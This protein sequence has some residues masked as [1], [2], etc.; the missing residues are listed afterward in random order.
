MLHIEVKD[1]FDD[2]DDAFKQ[3]NKNKIK[4]HNVFSLYTVWP[5]FLPGLT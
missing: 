3:D 2:Y 1:V 5:A 4:S